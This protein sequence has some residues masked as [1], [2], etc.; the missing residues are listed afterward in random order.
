MELNHR[1]LLWKD[2]MLETG[3]AADGERDGQS[4]NSATSTEGKIVIHVKLWVP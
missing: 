1:N 2:R 3:G 4:I